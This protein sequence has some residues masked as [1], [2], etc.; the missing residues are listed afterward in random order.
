MQTFRQAMAFPM[1]ATVIW[2]LWVLGQQTGIDGTS[3]LLALLLTV[4]WLVWALGL[5]G[6]SRWVLSGL[7]LATLLWLG[8]SWL[9]LALREAPAELPASTQ[10]AA[11]AAPGNL[12]IPNPTPV[13]QPWS[14]AALQAQLAAGRPVFVDF[15]AAWCVTC[16]Y[17]KKTT[18]A[19]AQVLA[20]FAQRQVVLMRADWTRRDPAI[21]QALTALGRS[22][23]PVYALYSS[24]SKPVLLSEL[25]SVSEVRT[26]LRSLPPAR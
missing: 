2:L 20:D 6:R 3:S 22:G 25:L 5:S 24:G 23:V 11:Q 12:S 14:E 16:Q 1:F 8:S 17:N 21:T 4:A 13:W 19:D 26:A 10:A 18:L 15:T 9:P 7:A